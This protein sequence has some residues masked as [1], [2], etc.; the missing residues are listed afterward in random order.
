MKD[1]YLK[2]ACRLLRISPWFG[3][4]RRAEYTGRV[5]EQGESEIGS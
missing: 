2:I 1:L 5:V 4:D 3:H